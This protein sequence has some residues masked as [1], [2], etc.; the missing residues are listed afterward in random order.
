MKTSRGQIITSILCVI[1]FMLMII[2][3]AKNDLTPNPIQAAT[4]HTGHTAV[5]L[6]LLSLVCTPIN[7]I[8]GLTA[9]LKIRK[10]LGL[11]AFFYAALHFIIFIFFDFKFNLAWIHNEIRFKPFIQIGLAALILFIPLAITSITKIQKR[12]G[13]SWAALHKSVYLVVI[14]VIMHFILATKGDISLP[15]LYAGFTLFLLLLRFFPL[16]KIKSRQVIDVIKSIDTFL[17]HKGLR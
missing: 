14:L 11:F 8:F 17:L 12:M 16:N 4:L 2:N 6:L 9:F 1:P 3:F 10:T 5:N 15:I 7:T 13:K